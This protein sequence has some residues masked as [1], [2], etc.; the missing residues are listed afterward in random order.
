MVDGGREGFVEE[1]VLELIF[2]DCF[3]GFCGVYGGWS[4]R[5]AC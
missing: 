3:Y 2:E 1:L 5:D 4:E